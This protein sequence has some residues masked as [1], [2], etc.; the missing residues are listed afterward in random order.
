MNAVILK[1]GAANHKSVKSVVKKVN[2]L[3]L[4][5]LILTTLREV[6]GFFYVLYLVCNWYEEVEFARL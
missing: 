6:K 4:N 1:K 3:K 5:S 2:L